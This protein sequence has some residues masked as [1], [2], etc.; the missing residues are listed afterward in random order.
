VSLWPVFRKEL[1][2][3]FFSPMAYVVAVI[4]LLIVGYLFCALLAYYSLTSLQA[5]QNPYMMGQFNLTERV[6]RP[7]FGDM[8]FVMLLM[9]PLLTMRLFAEERRSGTLEL[10]LTYP[11]RDWQ[12]IAGKFLSSLVVLACMLLPTLVYSLVLWRLGK[13][14]WGVLISAY[15]GLLLLAGAIFALGLWISSLTDSQ[16]V[17]ASATFGALLLFW[18]VGWASSLSGGITSQILDNISLLEHFESFAKGVFNSADIGFYI[19]FAA[20]FL[21]L[22]S[23]SLESRSWKGVS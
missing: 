4:F 23:R 8:A 12:I 1:R 9:T 2:T 5:M 6:L 10:L 18:M 20:F 19:I 16:I 17:A 21:F 11:L 22:T 13:I 15:S 7:L 14:E 3:Y